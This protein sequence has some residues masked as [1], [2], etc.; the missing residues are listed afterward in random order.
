MTEKDAKDILEAP[1]E[2]NAA[3]VLA[4][5]PGEKPAG[6]NKDMDE[7]LSE[8]DADDA[9][10]GE[11]DDDETPEEAESDDAEV[12]PADAETKAKD[13]P[14]PKDEDEGDDTHSAAD[15]EK[16]LE[17]VRRDGLDPDSLRWGR[18]RLIEHGLKRAKFYADQQETY[19]T[20]QEQLKE[21]KERAESAKESSGNAT[22]DDEPLDLNGALEPFRAELGEESAKALG[23][24]LKG[25]RVRANAREKLLNERLDRA[26]SLATIGL[27]ESARDRLKGRFPSLGEEAK[28]LEVAQKA[29][30]FMSTG[31]Y[32]S[33]D[34]AI[35]DASKVLDLK[36][37]DAAAREE[38]DEKADAAKANGT[39]TGK[40]RRKKPASAK[41]PDELETDTLAEL[42]KAHG[43]DDG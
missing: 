25:E 7:F 38:K 39:P 3:P 5:F 8:R 15:Y 2:K 13:E 37:A 23:D 31:D 33:I 18:K 21:L 16:A 42:E 10:Y 28:W 4:E 1:L 19:R 24:V 43:W 32:P 40:S 9:A 17:A 29:E 11:V 14:A 27:Y 35:R 30:G 20:Q 22:P 6:P 26:E 12:E 41:T 34:A 36:D